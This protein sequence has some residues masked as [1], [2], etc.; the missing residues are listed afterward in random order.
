MYSNHDFGRELKI[1]LS[2]SSDIIKIARWAEH[3][4]TIYCREFSQELD[5]VVMALSTMEHGPEFEYTEN[6]LRLLAELLINDA[7]D[8]LKKIRDLKS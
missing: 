3:V 7:T 2:K 6:E 8:P 1:I 4:Y 5:D